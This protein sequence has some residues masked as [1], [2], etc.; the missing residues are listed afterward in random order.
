VSCDSYYL[1]IYTYISRGHYPV[2]RKK[3][4]H[5]F[6]FLSPI[7]YRSFPIFKP[8]KRNPLLH[9]LSF[10]GSYRHVPVA[11]SL[12]TTLYLLQS[13]SSQST[14]TMPTIV[15]VLLLKCFSLGPAHCTALLCAQ[16]C[17]EL[18][19][20]CC[21]ARC[22]ALLLLHCSLHCTAHCWLHCL[23][24]CTAHCWLHCLLHC[25]ALL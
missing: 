21:T 6:T 16:C 7:I 12:P 5:I 3:T 8:T 15:Q 9:L 4:T 1:N 22:T 14:A 18:H 2:T 11:L 13:G 19:C 24:H 23:L 25:T 10:S 17:T 20:S